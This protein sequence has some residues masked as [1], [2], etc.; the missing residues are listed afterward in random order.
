MD[1]EFAIAR[2]MLLAHCLI[3]M[4]A[5]AVSMHA[6]YFAIRGSTSRHAGFRVKARRYAGICWP[7][8]VLTMV[9]GALVYPAYKVGVR[10][11]W[12]DVN[13]PDLTGWFE[14]KE[15]W[16]AIGTALA[17]AMWHYFRRSALD[18]IIKPDRNFW[19]G[20]SAMLVL[21]VICGLANIIIGCWIVMVR[22]V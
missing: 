7:L 19:A 22:S 6:A 4:A 13:R 9:T 16:A 3:G 20:Q 2:P 15:H 5:V 11:E 12:M 1:F 14:I 18:R 17:W 21:T 8:Y 10:A